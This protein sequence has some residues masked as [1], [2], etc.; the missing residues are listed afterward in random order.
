MNTLTIRKINETDE[1][2]LVYYFKKDKTFS[3]VNFWNIKDMPIEEFFNRLKYA[4]DKGYK[5]TFED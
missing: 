1:I 5:L 4:Q 3:V 2:R